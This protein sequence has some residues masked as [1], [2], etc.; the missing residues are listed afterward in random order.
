MLPFVRSSVIVDL[1]IRVLFNQDG[2]SGRLGERKRPQP[3]VEAPHPATFALRCDVDL[4]ADWN[5]RR[6]RV[7]PLAGRRPNTRGER[8]SMPTNPPAEPTEMPAAR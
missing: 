3:R 1:Q 8:S 5:G 7:Q 2:R 4:S 6:T